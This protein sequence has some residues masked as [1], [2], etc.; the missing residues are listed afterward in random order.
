MNMIKDYL[1]GKTDVDLDKLTPDDKLYKHIGMI[2][3]LEK[4]CAG[5]KNEEKVGDAIT[6]Y[7]NKACAEIL[8]TTGVFKNT[9]QGEKAFISLMEKMGFEKC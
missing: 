1:L 4:T 7:I 5:E 2:K 8:F 3:E 6:N 9:E